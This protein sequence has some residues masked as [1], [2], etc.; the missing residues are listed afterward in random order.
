MKSVSSNAELRKILAIALIIALILG[1]GFTSMVDEPLNEPS[2]DV[3]QEP[4]DVVGIVDTMG[5]FDPIIDD[6]IY[7][8]DDVDCEDCDPWLCDDC[9]EGMMTCLCCAA[10][11][12]GCELCDPSLYNY[13]DCGICFAC[14]GDDESF[15]PPV[16]ATSAS[17][18]VDVANSSQLFSALTGVNNGTINVIN[19]TASFDYFGQIVLDGVTLE[20]NLGA[21][22]LTLRQSSIDCLYIRNGATLN[23]TGPG[24]LDIFG[25]VAIA[26]F[27][28]KVGVETKGGTL[29]NNG[30]TINITSFSTHDALFVEEG[31]ATVTHVSG[32]VSISNGTVTGNIYG[33]VEVVGGTATINGN[34]TGVNTNGVS[35]GGNSTVTVNGNIALSGSQSVGVLIWSGPRAGGTDNNVTVNGTIT[36][37]E[38]IKVECGEFWDEFGQVRT[39]T[40]LTA[41]QYDS[42]VQRSGR[43]YRHFVTDLGNVFVRTRIVMSMDVANSTELDTALARVADGTVNVINITASFTY[44][45]TIFLVGGVLDLN[46]NTN[47][48]TIAEYLS[49]LG[50][51][52]NVTGLGTLEIVDINNGDVYVAINGGGT[53]NNNGATI[54]I[55]NSNQGATALEVWDGTATVT[56]VFGNVGVGDGGDN[57]TKVTVN[58]N[59]HGGVR[60]RYGGTI[61]I[62]GNITG[63][64]VFGIDCRSN[65][66]V[67][68]NGNITLTGPQ[69]VGIA[70]IS[71][72]YVGGS[73]NSVTVNGIISAAEYIRVDDWG[74]DGNSDPIHAITVLT[75]DQYDAIVQRGGR[76]YR[77]FITDLGNVFILTGPIHTDSLNESDVNA[78][79]STGEPLVLEEGADT[80]IS[81]DVL[82]AIKDSEGTLT[83][84]LPN[85][86][87]ITIRSE[88]ISDNPKSIDL[89]FDVVI[90]SRA[91][92]VYGVNVPANSVVIIPEASGEFG[93]TFSFTISAAELAAA[94][95]NG[96]TVGLFH[97]SSAGVITNRANQ[98][99]R[100]N[101]DGSVTLSLSSASRYVLSSTPPIRTG[102]APQ[103]GDERTLTLAIIAI[104][105]GFIGISGWVMYIAR[106]KRTLKQ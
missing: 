104:A 84:V 45:K 100:R 74:W 37:A 59:I 9:G 53:L 57:G 10:C 76:S 64:N 50:T 94:G 61:T 12:D 46:L 62:N 40:V 23:V 54:N 88:D 13:E 7:D 60:A 48:L 35:T 75:E 92:P 67:T 98:Q 31:I 69:S 1:T 18:A 33:G 32:G 78:A 80:T 11:Y 4:I 87:E 65:S 83:I 41:D 15:T 56:N 51:N 102:G 71:G 105:F 21:N 5:A 38:Y 90:T 101:T 52:L 39:T 77:H 85:G 16:E 82:Q 42:I 20:L 26:T 47:T 22:T 97:I 58:A 63:N 49:L 106:T 29:N 43:S 17:A 8:C 66:T 25:S 72:A 44:T 34:I 30:A 89:N 55:T 81:E 2:D 14:I 96:N 99:L 95:L 36:A 19:I 68:V 28:I 24:T 91:T 73:E 6:D 27:D 70:F 3:C 103:M 86:R 93:F 79:I